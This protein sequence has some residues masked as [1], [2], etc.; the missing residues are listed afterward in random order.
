MTLLLCAGALADSYLW[1]QLSSTTQA[2]AKLAG[3]CSYLNSTADTFITN[4]ADIA[5]AVMYSN[6]VT[7][8][9]ITCLA[10]SQTQT[11]AVDCPAWQL[12]GNTVGNEETVGYGAGWASAPA[13]I[14]LNSSAPTGLRYI[15]D[16][17]SKLP[18]I[19]TQVLDQAGHLVTSGKQ[20]S[21]MDRTMHLSLLV[22]LC[23]LLA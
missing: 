13:N 8:A 18:V 20:P 4:H 23:C 6:N 11:S 5:E 12:D 17:V 3:S 15:S 7:S 10:S 9:D 21:P 19:V 2:A 1:A 16:G 22:R 14:Q